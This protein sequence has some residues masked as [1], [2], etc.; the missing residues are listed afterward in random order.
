MPEQFDAIQAIDATV[1]QYASDLL[2]TIAA[3]KKLRT[4]LHTLAD[5]PLD[6]SRSFSDIFETIATHPEN[7]S[8]PPL[9]AITVRLVSM[10]G[11]LPSSLRD[12]AARQVLR[13][14]KQGHPRLLSDH[15][16]PESAQTYQQ[17]DALNRIHFTACEHLQPL[18]RSFPPYT[19]SLL[20]DKL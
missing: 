6:T 2:D 18:A 14:I 12:N 16:I 8:T 11:L 3:R 19:I 15:E 1:R 4:T 7:I 5:I 17:F 9:A 20:V 13:I 10:P